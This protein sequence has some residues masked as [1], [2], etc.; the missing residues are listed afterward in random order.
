MRVYKV[1]YDPALS[2]GSTH[3]S[4]NKNTFLFQDRSLFCLWCALFAFIAEEILVQ[5]VNLHQLIPNG[6]EKILASHKE[7]TN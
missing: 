5:T 4:A 1:V 2:C 7:G 3:L 6:L